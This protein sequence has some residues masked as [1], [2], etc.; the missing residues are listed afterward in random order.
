M[1]NTIV[2]FPE[3]LK[4][5]GLGRR[6]PKAWWTELGHIL[7][8]EGLLSMQMARGGAGGN[9]KFSYQR[10]LLSQL[11][12]QYLMSNTAVPISSLMNL[13]ASRETP[14][15]QPSHKNIHATKAFRIQLKLSPPF[16]TATAKVVT[17]PASSARSSHCTATAS[18]TLV[19]AQTKISSHVNPSS[20]IL[21]PR[22]TSNS[23]PPQ[24]PEPYD[25]ETLAQLE[26]RLR[27]ERAFLSEVHKLKPYK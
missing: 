26:S 15:Q 7:V 12:Q 27:H 17:T 16:S 5:F 8:D 13:T 1:L 6:H 19:T 23:T 4:T 22:K 10:F 14:S 18:K 2:G 25:R 3:R 11:G 20:D 24:P 21:T 9:A